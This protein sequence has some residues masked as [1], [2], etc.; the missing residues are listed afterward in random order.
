MPRR[1]PVDVPR[2]PNTMRFKDQRDIPK[3]IGAY[4]N[5]VHLL[6]SLVDSSS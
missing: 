2:H 3:A 4:Q 1:T 6:A 5:S